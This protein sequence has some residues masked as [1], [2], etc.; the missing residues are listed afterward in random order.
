[1]FYILQGEDEFSRAEALAKVR[2]EVPGGDPA[3]AELNTTVLD[4]GKLTLG[5][6]RHHC[7]TIPFLAEGRQVIVYGLLSRLAPGRKARD[8]DDTEEE[9]AWKRA[10]LQDLAAYLPDLPPT[11][12]LIFVEPKAIPAS[13]AIL[14]LA[15]AQTGD[16]FVQQF[17]QPKERDLPGWIQR[18]VR[19]KKG[20]MSGEAVTL[21][22]ALV[23]NDLRLLDQEIE[24]L[25]LYTGERQ[26]SSED[27]R[28]LVSR[29]REASIF[30]LV[31]CVGHRQSAEALRL[32]HQMLDDLEHPLY[33]LTMLARQVRILIQVSDLRE[34]RL[35]ENEMASRLKLHPFVVKKGLAQARNFTLAQLEAAHQRVVE[36]DWAIKTG[37]MED[38]LALDLLVVGLTRR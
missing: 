8:Q 31:D 14:K 16:T 28:A 2:A 5:E 33:L 36:T 13:Q 23:G 32:L 19:G 30:D 11:T 34:Q 18:R 26:I 1:M 35:S 12:T 38:V 10:Y 25:L 37:E 3:M 6:L 20:T 7:D 24:K 22:A 29:A 17:D 27:V 15:R 21:L 9:P 4:G